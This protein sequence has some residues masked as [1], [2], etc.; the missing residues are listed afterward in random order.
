MLSGTRVAVET[1]EAVSSCSPGPGPWLGSGLG[2]R[3]RGEPPM[4]RLSPPRAKARTPPSPS[5]SSSSSGPSLPGSDS[6]DSDEPPRELCGDRDC[7]G[8]GGASPRGDARGCGSGLRGVAR[9]HGQAAGWENRTLLRGNEG[10]LQARS[11][12]HQGAMGAWGRLQIRSEERWKGRWR[13]LRGREE[14]TLSWG[15]WGSSEGHCPLGPSPQLTCPPRKSRIRAS[16]RP[17]LAL[18]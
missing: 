11:G 17:S 1:S 18:S 15:V 8:G 3:G 6:R 16:A 2:R 7:Q 10:R 9:G 14:G 4:E 5:S 12:G 13:R